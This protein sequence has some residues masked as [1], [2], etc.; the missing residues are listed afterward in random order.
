MHLTKPSLT[1]IRSR[2]SK[3]KLTKAKLKEY[4]IDLRLYNKDRKRYNEPAL[5][6]DDYIKLRV[7]KLTKKDTTFK[8]LSVSPVLNSRLQRMDNYNSTYRSLDSSEGPSSTSRKEVLMYTGE[9][10]LIGI[11]TMHKSNMVPVF[12]SDDA[13]DLARM[14]RN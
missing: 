11:A 2:R 7:G 3:L 8:T 10:K 9:R 14:R 6:L 4:E 12:D 5:S 1:L 13:K